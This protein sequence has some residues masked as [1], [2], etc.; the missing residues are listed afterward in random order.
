MCIRDRCMRS[1][2][3]P[4]MLRISTSAEFDTR[5]PHWFG[6]AGTAEVEILS[7]FGKQGERM[8]LRA[9]SSGG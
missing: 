5:N 3:L 4:N 7:M 9:K 6:A 2:C 1:P 8:H